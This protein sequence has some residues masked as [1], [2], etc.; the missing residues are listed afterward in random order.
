MRLKSLASKE[1]IDVENGQKLGVLGKADL[2]IN[3]DTGE[4]KSL[5]LLNSGIMRLSS[6]R[7]HATL[8][9]TQI[10]AIGE[11]TILIKSTPLE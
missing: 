9:W 4:I 7:K 3:P 10:A 8:D 6:A 11:D 1:V 5:V 2:I